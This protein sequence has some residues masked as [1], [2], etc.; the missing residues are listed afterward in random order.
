[1]GDNSCSAFYLGC[2]VWGVLGVWKFGVHGLWVVDV[3]VCYGNN[4]HKLSVCTCYILVLVCQTEKQHVLLLCPC[5][6]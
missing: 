6:S 5:R 2:W 3:W 1:V 4:Q